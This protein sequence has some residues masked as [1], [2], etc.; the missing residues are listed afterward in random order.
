MACV[1]DAVR[2]VLAKSRKTQ[3]AL[4]VRWNASRQA[5]SNKFYRDYWS[6]NELVDIARFT[7]CKLVFKF[8]DGTEVAVETDSAPR[9]SAEKAQS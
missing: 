4:G 7:G 1:S 3:T 5:V 2:A 6:T 8:P 9:L